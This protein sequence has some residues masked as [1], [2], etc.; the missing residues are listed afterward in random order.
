[1]AVRQHQLQSIRPDRR[2]AAVAGAQHGQITAAQLLDLGLTRAQIRTRVE[3]G[4][5]HPVHRGVYSVGVPPSVPL[6]RWT[7]AVLAVGAGAVLSHGS[8]GAVWALSREP[9]AVEV[10]TPRRGARGRPGIVVHHAVVDP[11]DVTR[12]Q[13]LPL[14]TPARTMLDLAA[15]ASAADVDR[16]LQDARVRRLV[17]DDSLAATL[18]RNADRAGRPALAAAA[19]VPFTRSE[20]ERAFLALV[21]AHDLP[22][23]RT[24]VRVAGFEVDALWP[25]Q[26]VVVELDGRAAHATRAAHERDRRRD[27][28]LRAA[29]LIVLRF[30]WWDVTGDPHRVGAV[31]D[32]ALW[33]L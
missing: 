19:A 29:G 24:N 33:R 26:R 17:D 13:G 5:L 20:L 23:P 21:A 18:A 12:H 8:A 6:G 27:A 16:R 30:T 22:A 7:A 1:V 15:G 25:E 11:A 10:T 9:D 4:R 31:L 14:T 2:I 28:A 3:A 32:S